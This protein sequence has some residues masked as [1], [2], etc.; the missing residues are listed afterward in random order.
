[1]KRF[2][3]FTLIVLMGTSA[4][5]LAATTPEEAQRLTT[6]FQSYFGNEPGVVTVTPDGDAYRARIDFAPHFAKIPDPKVTATL[7]P[8]EI[9]LA[10]QGGG[11]W[12]VDQDQPL[13]FTFK[14]DGAVNLKGSIGSIKGTGVFDEAL[15]AFESSA[16]DMTEFGFQQTI[17]ERGA[18]TQVAYTIAAMHYDT[19]TTGTGDSADATVKGTI[20]D[21]RETVDTPAAP[22]GSMPPMQFSISAPSG[23]QETV[24]TGL[25]PRALTD[26]AAWLVARPSPEAITKDQAEF[27][28]KLRAVLPLWTNVTG[29]STLDN[30]SVN[31]MMGMF[32]MDKLDVLVDMNGIVADGRLREKFGLT[33]LKLPDGIVP[34]WAAELV[35]NN[36]TIDFNVS[37]FDLAAPAKLVIDNFDLSKDPPL[38]PAMEQQLLAALL[39]KSAVQI[40][41]GPS[42]VVSAIFNLTAEGSMTAGP[43]SAPSGSALVKLKGLDEIMTALQAAPPEMG[44]QQVT[45]MIVVAK[46]MAKQEPDGF[47]SWKI[48]STPT[49]SVTINGV[50]PMKMGGQ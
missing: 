31:T 5:A 1:M 3:A 45:P 13:S 44:M 25:K 6:L 34:P 24:A 28:D 15:G 9:T 43:V 7:T 47:L 29:T 18:T 38:P 42:E 50:D 19:T 20:T 2:T 37:E 40:G 21:L 16:T 41:L 17:T 46:G 23:S 14:V 8:L 11:K 22:D 32:G 49:G 48:D 36:F 10:D 26:L 39:P 33:G 4:P 30:L 12:K 35:P 27:K